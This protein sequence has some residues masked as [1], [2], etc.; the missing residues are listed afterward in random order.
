EFENSAARLWTQG[1]AFL[2]GQAFLIAEVY[3]DTSGNGNLRVKPARSPLPDETCPLIRT[4]QNNDQ[5]WEGR[6]N[7]VNFVS[8]SMDMGRLALLR[9][10]H[11]NHLG[12]PHLYTNSSWDLL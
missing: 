12:L 1:T 4:C 9:H 6:T 7:S 5:F 11:P 10:N 2:A 3:N 8:S